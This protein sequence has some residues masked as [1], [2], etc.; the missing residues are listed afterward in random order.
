[1]EPDFA[2]IGG[3]KP[4]GLC[5]SGLIDVVAELFR[6]GM[7]NGKG[8]FSR[9]G[10][11][12]RRDEYGIGSYVLAFAENTAAGRD[13][14]IFSGV[15]S[16]IT[17]LGFTPEDVER[18]MVAGGIGG[19]INIRNAIRI[20]MLPDLPEE[21]YSYIGNSSLSG[22]YAMLVS[23]DADTKLQEIA[24]SMT[25]MELSAQPGYMDEFIAACFLPHTDETLFPSINNS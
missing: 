4:V 20:G 25:Y 14:M 22:A 12:V 18:V 1:M 6:T 3:I 21:K 11:R 9:E 15:M 2:V 8:K 19:G 7:I 13:I 17:P 10:E 23:S 16:L 5:G 24:K